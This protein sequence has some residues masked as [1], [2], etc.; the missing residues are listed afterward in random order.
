MRTIKILL[1]F[2][3]IEIG[4]TQNVSIPDKFV[5]TPLPSKEVVKTPN[6]ILHTFRNTVI[7]NDKEYHL[8][9]GDNINID[10]WGY[11]ELSG[12]HIVGP[13]GKIT[14]PLVG[15]IKLTNLSR[16][17]AAKIISN[18]L[19]R[20]YLDLSVA[21]RVNEYASNR[22]LVLGRVSKPGEV[23]FNMTTPNLL[24]AISLAGGF[25]DASGLQ[26]EAHSLPATR[27][28][29]FRGQDKIVW[30]DLEP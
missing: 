21:V 4:C 15:P 13:D 10:V 11:Q 26:G 8:G 23:Q 22:V 27:C 14:L 5:R 3:L 1:L 30:I 28:A 9:T 24:E 2:L 12:K 29:I 19:S 20:Y 7:K 17:Q 18:K 6:D 25:S 16:E